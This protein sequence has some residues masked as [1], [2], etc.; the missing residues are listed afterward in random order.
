MNCGQ[1]EELMSDYI[2]NALNPSER[3]RVHPASSFLPHMYRLAGWHERSP[4]LGE[5]VSRLRSAGLAAGAHCCEYSRCRQGTLDRYSRAHWALDCR[6]AYGPRDFHFR[7]R[8]WMA[9]RRLR[10]FLRTGGPSYAILVPFTTRSCG[11]PIGHRWLPRLNL[12]LSS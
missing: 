9:G 12:E 4:R 10:A 1:C 8:A 5:K 11:P 2:E 7:T 6:A 3:E